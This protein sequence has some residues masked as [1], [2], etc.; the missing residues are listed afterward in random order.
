M[1][2]NVCSLLISVFSISVYIPLSNNVLLNKAAVFLKLVFCGRCKGKSFQKRTNLV[3]TALT[4]KKSKNIFITFEAILWL[5]LVLI[6]EF[7]SYCIAGGSISVA[8]W[9]S[10]IRGDL[11]SLT[12]EV[13]DLQG[14]VVFEIEVFCSIF[15]PF[16]FINV[17]KVHSKTRRNCR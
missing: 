17:K 14:I 5:S 12:S 9:I 16:I 13:V 4:F 1:H 6:F 3:P 10:S 7:E 15:T 11:S 8:Q 2:F